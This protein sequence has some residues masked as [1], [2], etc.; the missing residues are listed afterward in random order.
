MSFESMIEKDMDKLNKERAKGAVLSKGIIKEQETLITECE[1]RIEAANN[2]IS[3]LQLKMKPYIRNKEVDAEFLKM[4][5]RYEGFLTERS[6][7]QKA[8][9]TATES[10]EESKLNIDIEV[11]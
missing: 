9:Q 4:K 3:S 1:K 7:L 11:T 6:L 2:E 5:H 10:V 8:L